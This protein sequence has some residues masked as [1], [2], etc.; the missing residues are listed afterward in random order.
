MRAA[1]RGSCARGTAPSATLVADVGPGE[2]D[3]RIEAVAGGEA[4]FAAEL[5]V[6][7]ATSFQAVGTIVFGDGHR[8]RCST[9]GSGYLG[10]SLDPA[11]RHGAAVWRVEGGEG[12]FAGATG[13]ITS[14]VLVGDGGAVTD[15][16]FGVLFLA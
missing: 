11:G 7:G 12:Q 13:L 6:T 15:H 10:P 5:T 8:L 1:A 2:L 9:V 16:Q 4:A 3:G 14:N